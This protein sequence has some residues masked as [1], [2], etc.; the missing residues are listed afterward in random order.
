MIF[1]Y[2][3]LKPLFQPTWLKVKQVKAEHHQTA[4]RF[5]KKVSVS[6]SER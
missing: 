2:S 3:I 4:N 6:V 1:H 5:Q